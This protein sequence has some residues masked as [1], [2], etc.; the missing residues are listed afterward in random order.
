MEIK[1]FKTTQE[2]FIQKCINIHGTEKY[3]FSETVFNGMKKKVT[4]Y[5]NKHKEHF[6]IAANY[7]V[8]GRGCAKCSNESTRTTQEEFI[9][10]CKEKHGDNFEYDRTVYNKQ[11]DI[12]EIYCNNHKG[13]FFQTAKDHLR[14]QGSQCN[15]CYGKKL[16]TTE[17]FIEKSKK[18]YPD[19]LDYS[20]TKYV[21][22]SEPVTLKCLL[23][24]EFTTT[25]AL[26][27]NTSIGCRE[28]NK[29]KKH[30]KESVLE[31]AKLKHGDLYEYDLSDYKNI[32]SK[33]KLKCEK[34]GWVSVLASSLLRNGKCPKCHGALD[35]EEFIN[36]SKNIHGD[37]YGYE[38]VNYT[39]LTEKVEIY[40]NDCKNYYFQKPSE[41]LDGCGCNLC[42]TTERKTQEQF[43]KEANKFHNNFY[44]YDKTVYVNNKSMITVHCPIHG[45]FTVQAK[46]HLKTKCRKCDKSSTSFPEQYIYFV[47]K[48]TYPEFTIQNGFKILNKELDIFIKEPNIGIEYDGK[49]YHGEDAKILKDIEKNLHFVNNNIQIIRVREKGLPEIEHSVNITRK[50]KESRNITDLNDSCEQLVKTI[51]SV[52]NINN[53]IVLPTEDEIKIITDTCF[54]RYVTYEEYHKW[55]HEIP[56]NIR[57]HNQPTFAEFMKTYQKPKSHPSS[58]RTMYLNKGWTSWTDFFTP[59]II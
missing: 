27:L 38:K 21:N 16:L 2:E 51:N 49:R 42:R 58:P 55:F 1:R 41:H 23:H 59:P 9:K 35:T 22:S 13:Y 52:L 25:P 39:K 30:T 34:H 10:K 37:K 33:V 14:K 12:I 4:V 56:S 43:I 40:C 5:C 36:R 17:E 19:R 7:L 20:L 18:L 28:C 15:V 46:S 6:T 47:I 57:P 45:D 8:G 3:D 50:H 53:N 54:Y 24:G 29:A 44:N 48:N 11:S 31:Q 26:H 32:S